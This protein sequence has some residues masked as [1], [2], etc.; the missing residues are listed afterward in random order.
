MGEK[1]TIR[2]EQ[3]DEEDE[4]RDENEYTKEKE[5]HK[6]DKWMA[7]GMQPRRNW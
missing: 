5:Q 1:E 2:T 3:Q 4:R 6:E 7:R